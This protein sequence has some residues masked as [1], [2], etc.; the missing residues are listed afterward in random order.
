MTVIN[1][2]SIVPNPTALV[3]STL[4]YKCKKIHYNKTTT[5]DTHKF[6]TWTWYTNH[7]HLL[8]IFELK[9]L[10]IVGRFQRRDGRRWEWG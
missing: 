2:F 3:R 1:D 9:Q 7:G 8:R 4:Q 10:R 6:Q 5:M